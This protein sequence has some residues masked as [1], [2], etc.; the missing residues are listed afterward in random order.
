MVGPSLRRGAR[1]GSGPQLLGCTGLVAG[2]SVEVPWCDRRL[3]RGPHHGLLLPGARHRLSSVTPGEVKWRVRRPK[4][5]S[6]PDK[7]SLL[8]SKRV[9]S[10][11][12]ASRARSG[13]RSPDC[14]GK[15]G[16][17]SRVSGPGGGEAFLRERAYASKA[18]ED[19]SRDRDEHD[20]VMSGPT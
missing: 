5:V 4:G 12:V 10:G 7:E 6:W 20:Q 1:G 19:K 13:L 18:T 16:R 17:G 11:A 15:T 9:A 3:G 14:V 2:A 8:A